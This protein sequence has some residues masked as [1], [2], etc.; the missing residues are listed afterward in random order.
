MTGFI[1]STL[2][3]FLALALGQYL[4]IKNDI[5][6]PSRMIKWIILNAFAFFISYLA[7]LPFPPLF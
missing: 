5:E 4:L 2:A 7:G 6:I 1:V 3:Y